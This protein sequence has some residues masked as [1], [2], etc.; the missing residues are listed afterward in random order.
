MSNVQK[1]THFTTSDRLL[2]F[3]EEKYPGMSRSAQS[4]ELGFPYTTVREWLNGR[5]MPDKALIRLKE[6]GCDISWL[7]AGGSDRKEVD[8]RIETRII[9][10]GWPVRGLAAADE[11]GGTRVPDIDDLDDPIHPPEGLTCIPVKGDSMSPVLLDGQY[12][13]IDAEREGFE[14]DGGIVV[15]YIREPN[16]DDERT[17][18][19]TGTFVKRCYKGE[20]VYYFTSINEYSPFDAWQDHCR[21]WPVI[22]VWFAGKGKPPNGD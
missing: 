6:L 9:D 18:P 1:G 19:M 7:L 8:V 4:K 15:A 21:I 13:M 3:L 2:L 14:V 12:A 10:Q 17:E 22:G 5:R 16:P 20:G 11:S